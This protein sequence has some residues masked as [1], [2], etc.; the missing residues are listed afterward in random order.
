MPTNLIY[1]ELNNLID[2]YYKCPFIHIKEQILL[3]INLLTDALVLDDIDY[4]SEI[5]LE[6]S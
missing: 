5:P 6:S 1:K 3:D 4:L 2:D